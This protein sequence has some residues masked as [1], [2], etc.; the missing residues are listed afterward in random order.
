MNLNEGDQNDATEVAADTACGQPGTPAC[1]DKPTNSAYVEQ[2]FDRWTG[3]KGVYRPAAATVDKLPAGIYS[4]G[5]DNRGLY[6]EAKR[7]PSDYL[8][9]LPGLPT[10]LILNEVQKFWKRENLFCKFG[11]LHKRGILMCG[12]AGCGKTSII[13][14]VCNDT[15]ARDGIVLIVENASVTIL[16]LQAIR[17][18]EP[19]RALLT[20][21]EDL[22]TF[23]RPGKDH[24]KQMLSMYDG[25]NQV[26]HVVHLA[27]TNHPEE[28]EDRII[29]RP[30]R[31][32]MVLCLGTPNTDAR[33]AYLRHML[34]KGFPDDELENIV[35]GT[36]GL[37]LAHLREYLV[38]TLCF[39]KTPEETL[40]RLQANMKKK[41]TLDTK[42]SIVG[43]GGEGFRFQYFGGE[44]TETRVDNPS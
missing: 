24:S 1:G 22:D 31:F 2:V 36:K 3:A 37:S 18:I 25:E 12:P 19:C 33:R 35:C 38:A 39:D 41:P 30:S 21:T 27:T 4:A 7:F 15:I 9:D 34:G 13:R 23:F 6:L 26:N 20:V 14:M 42:G 32:D 8:L 43:F 40:A 5:Q 10:R 28:L 44:S 16:A 17:E 29:Q 11:F